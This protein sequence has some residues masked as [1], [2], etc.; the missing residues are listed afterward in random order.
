MRVFEEPLVPVGGAPTPAESAALAEALIAYRERRTPDDFS[1]LTRFLERHPKS[2][3]Q[4]AVRTGL[5]IE[6]YHTAHYSLALAA[7]REAW[8]LAK[9]ATEVR[10]KALAD[11]AAG[12][13]AFMLARIGRMTELEALLKSVEG[14][15]FVGSATERIAGAREGLWNMQHRPEVSFR[16]GPLA[17]HRI[18]MAT[19][20]Q[21]EAELAIFNSVSTQRG[22]S[23]AQVAELSQP[24]GLNYQMAFREAG[25]AFCVPAVVHWKLDHYAA[26]VR[27][28]GDRY[29]LQDPTFRDDVWATHEALEAEASGYFLVPPGRLPAGWRSVAAEEGRTIWGK[30]VTSSSDPGPYGPRDPKA[31]GGPC[32]GLAVPSVHLM[33]V[34]LSLSDE[35]LGYAPPLGPEVRFTVRYNHREAFQPATFTYANFGPKWTCDWVSYLTDNPLSPS[36][37]V[38]HYLPGGGMRTFKGFDPGTQTFAFEQYDQTRLIRTGP[39]SYEL[40]APDGSRIVF[41]Q[42]DGAAGTS[43]RIF[44][45][46]VVDPQG[47]A[48]TLGYDSDLRLVSLTD[49]LGQVTLLAYGDPNDLYKITSVTDPFG[50]VATFAYDTLGRLTSIGD[51]AGMMSRFVYEGTGDFVTALITPYGTNTFTRGGTGTTRWLETL[52]PDGSRDRVEFNQTTN[53]VAFSEPAGSVPQGMNTLNQWL[54]GRNTYYWSRNACATAYGDYRKARVYHWLHLDD[55]ASTS[56]ILESV[57]EPLEGRVWYD[58]AGQVSAVRNGSTAQPRH[59]G[60]VLDDG[61]TQLQTYAYNGFGQVTNSIDP[62]GREF[63]Y[64]YATNGLDLLEV[65]QTRGA[66]N[67]LLWRATYNAQHLPLTLT[68]AAGQTRSYTYNPRGQLLT[69]TN[70][71]GE[72]TTYTYDPNGYRIKVDGPLPG[73]NDTVTA[74]YDAFGR[75]RTKTDESGHTLTFDY[76][77]LDRLTKV[78]FPDGTSTEFTFDRLDP[79]IIRDR[80]GRQTLLEYDAL[81]QLTKRTDPLGRVTRF[82][83]CSCGDLRSL[84]DP[85][86]RTTFWNKDVQGRLTSKQY[87]DGSRVT[88]LYENTTSRVRQIMDEKQQ[89]RQFTYHRDDA[90]ASITYLNA[91]VPTP[92]VSF[93]YD[94]NYPRLS[95][96]TDGTG[97]TRYSYHPIGSSPALGAGELASEDGPLPNDTL[98]YGYDELG[99]VVSTAIGGVAVTMTHDAAG[100]VVTTASALGVFTNHYDG[101]S[102][103]LLLQTFPNG[104][105]TQR[106][107]AGNLADRALQRI[108]HR[109]GAM[110]VSEFLYAH[111]SSANRI[112]TWS[113][114]A[115]AQ[116]PSVF[117]FAYDAADQLL[118]AT[119][120]NAGLLVNAFDYAYDA[121]GNR[122]RERT[123]NT[124]NAATYNA[125]NQL[126]TSTAAGGAHTNEWDAEDRLAAVVAGNRRTEF[127]YDGV[128]RMVEIR[129]LENGAEISRRRFVYSG[130]DLAEERDGNG[131]VTKRFF[132]EGVKLETGPHAGAYYYTRDHLGSIRELTDGTGAVRARYA[133]D[134]YGRRAKLSGDLDADFGFTGLFWVSEANLALARFR[135]YDPELGRWLSRDPLTRAEEREGA[136][137]YAYVGNNP[138]N[139]TDPLGLMVCCAKEFWEMV[140]ILVE[141]DRCATEE[142]RAKKV[143]QRINSVLLKPEGQNLTPEQYASLADVCSDAME[144]YQSSCGNKE[145][146]T[147]GVIR[148]AARH[149]Y[150]TEKLC[151]PPPCDN[152]KNDPRVK[153]R[154]EVRRQTS[155]KAREWKRRHC[156]SPLFGERC[157]Y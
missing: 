137:L 70:P 1:S 27:R 91:Q 118:S 73:T 152:P 105:T 63:S 151:S 76:D 98:T 146:R 149:E 109:V 95:A 47:N 88:Y 21:A 60:R 25:A 103:R 157:W 53:L 81:R 46:R 57:K 82:Q 49:A 30:G 135:F 18:K 79:V 108:T 5:G 93:A 2:A 92:A 104:Q 55:L 102:G 84:T 54:H 17:L 19:D 28:E 119:V 52:Y 77:A 100:R 154:E 26:I 69:E 3:W 90:L 11:R 56:G 31:G 138:V 86:G 33:L 24:I 45:T 74:T 139:M 8:E 97:V 58:Y 153:R 68:D 141:Q 136:N 67:E 20:P 99:R 59:V 7:W 123:G 111:D 15:T 134:P 40:V 29:L 22:C 50:R 107:Y 78:T 85:L 126:S 51:V 43:R 83:W 37:D 94:P 101:P 122:L 116:P 12:E 41:A 16:C 13:L 129:L 147:A 61:G 113:Q 156:G 4:A 75:V 87:G 124:T 48:V 144:A 142:A 71:K 66:N 130:N 106:D 117:N 72:T 150:C 10:A 35:P 128:G 32:K 80:A 62:L 96:M 114:Q 64:V 38:K 36:S 115:G 65:R 127:T 120:T 133:Y 148:A 143:C 110:P 131:A 42:S 9:D 132:A 140:G 145:E 44:M 23:L 6:Y 112:K 34:N 155:E 14:R 125:L 89:I 121:A 39:A